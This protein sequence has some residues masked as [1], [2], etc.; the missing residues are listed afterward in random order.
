MNQLLYH[1]L[2]LN[3]VVKQMQL[4]CNN[5]QPC[6]GKKKKISQERSIFESLHVMKINLDWE[7]KCCKNESVRRTLNVTVFFMKDWVLTKRLKPFVVND[8]C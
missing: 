2:I 4:T 5:C 7:K 8:A 6:E 3:N 1:W